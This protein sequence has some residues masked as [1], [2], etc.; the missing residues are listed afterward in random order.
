MAA[1]QGAANTL[2]SPSRLRIGASVLCAVKYSCT[3]AGS[4]P[5]CGSS[6]PGTLPRASRNSRTSAT[7]IEVSC[8]QPQRAQATTPKCPDGGRVT[9]A[10][11]AS[12]SPRPAST[13]GS[14]SVPAGSRGP[15]WPAWD[16]WTSVIGSGPCGEFGEHVVQGAVA[17]LADD[18]P[19][20]AVVLVEH[21]RAGDGGRRHGAT[22]V[23][24]NL[25][26]GIVEARVADAEILHESVGGR[27]LVPDIAPD[28]PDI[29][30]LVLLGQ[31]GQRG[32]FL[33][34]GRAPGTPEVE[35]DHLALVRPR[36]PP[37]A[38]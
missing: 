8:R 2:N 9:G 6:D 30:R 37:A 23:E 1:N 26:R 21:Q 38:V 5:S 12:R 19:G 32:G 3:A 11:A 10:S 35:H 20:D 24:R 17:G 29:L 4:M 36:V 31:H 28:E 34:A 33:A 27:R 14:G 13:T 16:V 15:A 25:V 18:P 22:E 7:R